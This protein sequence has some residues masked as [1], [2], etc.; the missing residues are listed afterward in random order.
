MD[1]VPVIVQRFAHPIDCVPP[2]RVLKPYE[3]IQNRRPSWRADLARELVSSAAGDLR[4]IQEDR[5]TDPLVAQ[6]LIPYYQA[7]DTSKNAASDLAVINKYPGQGWATRVYDDKLD[8]RWLLEAYVMADL[9]ASDIAQA[10]G[11]DEHAIWWYERMFFDVRQQLDNA[12]WLA[13]RVLMPALS[14]GHGPRDYMMKAVGWKHAL[15]ITGVDAL[16]Q[17]FKQLPTAVRDHLRGLADSKIVIDAVSATL[18]RGEI[19]SFERPHVIEGYLQF[20]A[21][22]DGRKNDDQSTVARHFTTALEILNGTVRTAGRS[23]TQKMLGSV[24]AQAE[25]SKD[26]ARRRAERAKVEDDVLTITAGV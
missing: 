16:S 26:L 8:D 4:Q 18:P 2:A 5:N 14:Y 20:C 22:L 15:G 10:L 24:E 25:V 19:K 21:G 17:Y 12:R 23:D 6:Q 1:V 3:D 11:T 9:P 7:R 13:A